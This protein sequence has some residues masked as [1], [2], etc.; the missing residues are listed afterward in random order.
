MFRHRQVNE[1]YPQSQHGPPSTLTRCKHSTW[2]FWAHSAHETW[3]S[4]YIHACLET[5]THTHTHTQTR[6]C[7]SYTHTHGKHT[8]THACVMHAHTR[9]PHAHTRETQ[10]H[11][12]A[13]VMHAHT[14]ETHAHTQRL[15]NP[16]SNI[17]Q[18]RPHTFPLIFYNPALLSHSRTLLTVFIPVRKTQFYYNP[19]LPSH[20]RTLLIFIPVRKT[21]F[22]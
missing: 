18:T 13:C 17:C 3:Q 10:A 22:Y 16:K 1:P 21:Q 4:P 5:H 19:P 15:S 2:P 7:D 9:D 12:H 14:R 6:L 20:S 8:H 11:T